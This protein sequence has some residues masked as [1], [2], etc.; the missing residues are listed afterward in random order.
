[1]AR[2]SVAD[3]LLATSISW[4]T[5]ALPIPRLRA[6]TSTLIANSAIGLSGETYSSATASV[7]PS[8]TA[9]PTAWAWDM[10]R[11]AYCRRSCASIRCMKRSSRSSFGN[12]RKCLATSEQSSS[13]SVRRSSN[14]SWMAVSSP[15]KVKRPRICSACMFDT[16]RQCGG[17]ILYNTAQKCL[18]PAAVK[19]IVRIGTKTGARLSEAHPRPRDPE[20]RHHRTHREHSHEH[21]TLSYPSP[22]PPARGRN[23]IGRG[24]RPGQPDTVRRRGASAGHIPSTGNKSRN[25]GDLAQPHQWPRRLGCGLPFSDCPSSGRTTFSIDARRSR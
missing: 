9:K 19:N 1:M 20:G 15:T 13:D 8:Y 2:T 6:A 7:F 25:S 3:E 11:V 22:P 12:A 16:H 23:R 21:P 10:S 17:F 4:L 24:A 5:S 14:F 18:T